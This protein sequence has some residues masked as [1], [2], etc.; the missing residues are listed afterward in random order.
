MVLKSFPIITTSFTLHATKIPQI[1]I[2]KTPA[3]QVNES[4]CVIT[5]SFHVAIVTSVNACSLTSTFS[6]SFPLPEALS[7][8]LP[9]THTHR[10][11]QTERQTD[12]DII[13]IIIILTTLSNRI[14]FASTKLSNC[15]SITSVLV[16]SLLSTSLQDTGTSSYC[17]TLPILCN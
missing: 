10:H 1:I 13:L 8:R 11:R 14:S 17:N 7:S 3:E 15:S 9:Y 16:R 5:L 12:D 6:F 4:V 2:T